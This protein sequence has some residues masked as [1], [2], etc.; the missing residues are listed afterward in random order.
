MLPQCIYA[1]DWINGIGFTPVSGFPQ[2]LLLNGGGSVGHGP[3]YELQINGLF[4]I[5]CLIVRYDFVKKYDLVRQTGHIFPPHTPS[6]ASCPFIL[7]M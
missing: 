3:F 7:L 4:S 5:N 2:G 1:W 6:Y